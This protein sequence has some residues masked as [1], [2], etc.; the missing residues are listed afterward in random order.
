MSKVAQVERAERVELGDGAQSA[1]PRLSISVFA[2]RSR[3]SRKALRLYDRLGLLTPA[4][5]DRSNG[6]RFYRTGQLQT[7]R[8]IALLRR[9]DMPLAQVAELVHAAEAERPRLLAAY[10]QAV[11]QRVAGQRELV[12][13]L[14]HMFAGDERSYDMYEIKERAVPA[15]L[16]LTEQRHTT[17]EGLQPWLEVT[18]G[19]LWSTAESLGGG[20]APLFVI[21]H[22]QVDEDNDGPVEVC[23]PINPDGQDLSQVATRTEPAHREA[24]TRIKK[25]QVEFP[26]ILSAYDAVEQWITENGKTI[27]AGPR[28][29][30]FTDF[31]NAGPDDEVVDIAFPLA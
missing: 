3:L 13:H 28:E 26:Q 24:Y 1:D 10:W 17:V 16:V 23:L 9:V 21:Y 29:V 11:E 31:M 27:G 4:E 12:A 8:L 25:A 14:Q 18:F 30:Y 5:V 7:A 15:Q 22:G 2:R 20:S 19:R 6:Y